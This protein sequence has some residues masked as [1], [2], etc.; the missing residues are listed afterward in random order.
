MA[1]QCVATSVAGFIQQLAVAYVAHGYYFYVSG[2]I[3]EHKDPAETDRKIITQYGIAV[4]KWTRARRKKLGLANAHYLRY[5][6]FFVILVNH[7]E[8]PFFSAEAR[9]IRD[10]RVHPLHCMGYSIGCRPGR[11]G[12][13]LH[14]SVRID[15]SIY[16]ELKAGFE[17]SSVHRAAEDLAKSL[18]ALPVEPYAPVRD[19]LRCILRA[20]NRRRRR[21]G[22]ELVPET[23]LR[24]WRSPVKPFVMKRGV[25]PLPAGCRPQ[26][27]PADDGSAPAG[28]ALTATGQA[29]PSSAA[30]R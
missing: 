15:R 27:G 24:S 1:Y 23:A 9:R 14:A 16:R 12:G 29:P 4:S 22:L 5:R 2:V 26:D 11:G 6:R 21:A 18:R 10:I 19:Q 30:Q 28:P 8:Q 13:A 20:V 25:R 17:R 3:P 7:G